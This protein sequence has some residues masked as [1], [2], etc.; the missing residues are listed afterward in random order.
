LWQDDCYQR[1]QLLRQ[2][3]FRSTDH[4][5]LLGANIANTPSTRPIKYTSM[6]SVLCAVAQSDVP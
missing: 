4:G 5:K 1:E 3:G 2:S 6:I